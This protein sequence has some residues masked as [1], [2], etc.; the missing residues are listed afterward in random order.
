MKARTWIIPWIQGPR[1]SRL[2]ILQNKQAKLWHQAKAVWPGCIEIGDV[3][4]SQRPIEKKSLGKWGS[5]EL[6][7]GID[8]YSAKACDRWAIGVAPYLQS[9]Q[10]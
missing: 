3:H 1:V 7:K 9:A 2:V 10:G 5:L 6:S 8:K 4:E